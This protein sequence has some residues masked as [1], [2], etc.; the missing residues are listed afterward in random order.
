MG[1][2]CETKPRVLHT[3]IY[4]VLFNNHFG[5]LQVTF[6]ISPTALKYNMNTVKLFSLTIF[7]FFLK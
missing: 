7:L 3:F 4:N 2:S 5:T 1:L 6:L